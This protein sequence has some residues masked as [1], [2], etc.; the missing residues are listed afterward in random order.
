M[1]TSPSPAEEIR[2]AADVHR[3][4][5]PDYNDARTARPQVDDLSS[6]L[7]VA[8]HDA[9]LKVG[10]AMMER[11]LTRANIVLTSATASATAYTALLGLVY[12]TAHGR[13]LPP[14]ALL[15]VLYLGLAITLTAFYVGYMTP[16]SRRFHALPTELTQ[17]VAEQRLATFLTWVNNSAMSRSWALR[18][19]LV[20]LGLGL[21]LLPV[22]FIA[23]HG[24][25]VILVKTV[26][27]ALLLMV[28]GIET[29]RWRRSRV[30]QPYLPYPTELGAEMPQPAAEMPDAWLA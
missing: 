24:A 17:A 26:P 2:A 29:W 4:L 11:S 20:S 12:A 3:E 30:I 23:F 27:I 1:S 14:I 5:G 21:V 13:R 18:T 8:V 9:Y 10:Q 6:P 19:A 28:A 22:G 25:I 7:L 15:P 16:R